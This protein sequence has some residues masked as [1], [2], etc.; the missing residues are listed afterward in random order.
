MARARAMNFTWSLFSAVHDES[1]ERVV[2][3]R[4]YGRKR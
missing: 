3:T 4:D 1:V 2:E